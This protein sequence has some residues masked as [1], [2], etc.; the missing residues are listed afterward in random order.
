MKKIEYARFLEYA[1]IITVSDFLKKENKNLML[2]IKT[3]HN[4]FLASGKSSYIAQLYRC[5]YNYTKGKA[6]QEESSH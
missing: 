2:T 3:G 4:Q 6:R 1:G 5:I